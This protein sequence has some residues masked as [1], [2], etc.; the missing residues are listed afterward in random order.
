MN[1]KE[2]GAW[3]EGYLEDRKELTPENVTRIIAK[4][5]LITNGYYEP[6][7]WITNPWGTTTNFRYATQKDTNTNDNIGKV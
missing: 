5:K 4:S 3:L 1:A 7:P 2:F 6:Y